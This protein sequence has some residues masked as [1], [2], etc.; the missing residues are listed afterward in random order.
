MVVLRCFLRKRPSHP[1][2]VDCH[3]QAPQVKE[4]ARNEEGGGQE[5]GGPATSSYKVVKFH[6]NI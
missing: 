2:E 1:L 4:R 6:L 3:Q 5:A